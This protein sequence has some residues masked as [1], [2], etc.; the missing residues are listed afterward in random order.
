MTHFLLNTK[1]TDYFVGDLHGCYDLLMGQLAAVD[2]DFNKDRL[3]S[4]GD[5][6]DRG[7]HSRKCLDL[8]RMPWFHAVLGNH[9]E[10]LLMGREASAWMQN[11]GNWVNDINDETLYQYKRLVLEKMPLTNTVDTLYGKIGIVHAESEKGWWNNNEASREKNLWARTKITYGLQ[12]L[13]EDI[14]LVVVGHTP[15]LRVQ[16]LG[17]VVYIDTGAVFKQKLTVLTAKQLFCSEF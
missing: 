6:I 7:P 13:V 2:F 9:E 10:F 15:T 1:G 14:D 11:G 8:L 4:V 16:K 3:F 5:L 12:Y 17:N